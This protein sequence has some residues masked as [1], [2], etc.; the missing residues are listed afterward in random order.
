VIPPLHV[1]VHCCFINANFASQ[2]AVGVEAEEEEGCGVYAVYAV[3]SVRL[4]T[5]DALEENM[6]E[7]TIAQARPQIRI[8]EVAKFATLCLQGLA[9]HSRLS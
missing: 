8:D 3:P 2:E 9:F 5:I 6:K 7:R 4:L 1:A